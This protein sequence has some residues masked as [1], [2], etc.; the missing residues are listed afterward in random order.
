MTTAPITTGTRAPKTELPIGPLEGLGTS[1]KPTKKPI[2][3]PPPS[4]KSKV[5]LDTEP[6]SELGA[7]S[8]QGT[9]RGTVYEGKRLLGAFP[10]D[11]SLPLGG[12]SISVVCADGKREGFKISVRAG[13]TQT[14]TADCTAK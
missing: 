5:V 13:A 2:P 3:K 9:G 12:H 8:V 7:V 10:G 11:F 1:P 14:L 4:K 6:V